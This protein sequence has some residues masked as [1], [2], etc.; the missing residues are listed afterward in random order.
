MRVQIE[1]PHQK[2]NN[3]PQCKRCQAYFHTKGYCTHRPR[4]VKC[5]ETRSTEQ[6]TLPKTKPATYLHCGESHP[7]SYR[8]CISTKKSYAQ[9]FLLPGQQ[10]IFIFQISKHTGTI[11]RSLASQKTEE[12]LK[13]TYDQAT[14]SSI[15]TSTITAKNTQ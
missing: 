7:A 1:P 15:E 10:E 11:E 4:C 12:R 13:K 3:I 6:C 2:Q 5:G 9:G 8:G 14:G